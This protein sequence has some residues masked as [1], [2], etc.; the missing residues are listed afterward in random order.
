[1]KPDDNF[2]VGEVAAMAGVP[3]RTVYRAIAT[4]ELKAYRFNARVL[5]ITSAFAAAWLA[6]CEVRALASAG[7]TRVT[8]DKSKS[9]PV[10][11]TRT[12]A[13]V[14]KP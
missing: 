11:R 14:T 12:I 13:A 5:R 4:G 3:S 8:G 1:M 7:K 10:P 2:T 6:A 9:P